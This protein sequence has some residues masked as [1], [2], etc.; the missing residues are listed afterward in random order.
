MNKFDRNVNLAPMLGV[1]QNA[2]RATHALTSAYTFNSA[3]PAIA[4]RMIAPETGTIT[5][6]YVF[7]DVLFG[8]PGNLL[9]EVRGPH[10]TITSASLLGSKQFAGI[11]NDKWSKVTLDTPVAVTAGEIYWIIVGAVTADGS[12]NNV[13][14]PKTVVY[15][16]D[17]LARLFNGYTTTNGFVGSTNQG[18]PPALVCKFA[19]GEYCGCPYTDTGSYTSNT[20]HKG[21]LIGPL[22]DDVIVSGALWSSPSSTFS[23]LRIYEGSQLPNATPSV[24]SMTFGNGVGAAGAVMFTPVRLARGKSYRAVMT[25]SGSSAGQGYYIINGQ[26]DWPELGTA[27]GMAGG[28]ICST[29]GASGG[30]S[31]TDEYDKLSRMS[32]I[33][34][35]AK[36]VPAGAVANGG[37]L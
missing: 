6:V 1:T 24:L 14:L 21:L 10:G 15:P 35:D 17:L 29:R 26:A 22:S 2:T 5:D 4:A 36:R 33:I 7:V 8:S 11:G 12:N 25:F 19:S 32:L 20:D 30:L 31:W 28:A 37:R 34:G 9:L 3:G 13:L 23:G 18:F 27:V 16:N